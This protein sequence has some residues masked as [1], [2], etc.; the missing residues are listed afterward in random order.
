MKDIRSYRDIG[1]Q[2][3]P[4]SDSSHFVTSSKSEPRAQQEQ[5]IAKE[6]PGVSHHLRSIVTK[7]KTKKFNPQSR[8][9]TRRIPKKETTTEL[10][11]QTNRGVAHPPKKGTKNP[12]P[13]KKETN[14]LK[15]LTPPS[16]PK[17]RSPSRTSTSPSLQFNPSSFLRTKVLTN[18]RSS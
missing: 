11:R 15:Q 2:T 7:K 10:K 16:Q 14:P 18:L 4:K 17:M 1:V 13:Q 6:I 9:T 8:K 3:D 12:N 5:W